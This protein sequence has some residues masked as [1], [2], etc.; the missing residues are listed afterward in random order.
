MGR[1]FIVSFEPVGPVCWQTGFDALGVRV[2]WALAGGAQR[3]LICRVGW[4]TGL[5]ALITRAG[6]EVLVWTL[7]RALIIRASWAL[8]VGAQDCLIW[9]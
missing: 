4:Q 3:C 1:V 9:P 6:R 5:C 2:G 8:G 7:R